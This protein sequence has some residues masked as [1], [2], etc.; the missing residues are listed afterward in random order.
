MGNP[1]KLVD[2]VQQCNMYLDNEMPKET[3]I[4]FLKALNDNPEYSEILHK[5]KSFR[6]FLKSN[7]SRHKPS[8]AFLKK[9]KDNNYKLR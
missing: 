9:L 1:S 7:L 4:Q 6:N 3:A 8:G 5:E 2:I